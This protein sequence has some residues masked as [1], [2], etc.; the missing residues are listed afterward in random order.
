MHIYYNVARRIL[1]LKIILPKKVTFPK[2]A[3]CISNHISYLD[4]FV[5]GK[6]LNPVFIGKSEIRK[7]PVVGFI[8]AQIAGM[9]FIDRRRSQVMKEKARLTH[10]I[11]N[12]KTRPILFF[13]EGTT[14][15]GGGIIPFKPALFEMVLAN[16]ENTIVPFRIKYSFI[17]RKKIISKTDRRVVAWY[18]DPD[19]NLEDPALVKHL[20]KV[21]TQ[22]EITVEVVLGNKIK[23]SEFNDRGALTNRAQEEIQKLF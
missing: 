5:Y 12:N 14:T 20:F 18:N 22:S 13:P 8:G 15:D 1:G 6:V 2:Q 11:R 16:K 4:I 3:I 23:V 17:G 21:F 19:P 9:F 7:W 10:F